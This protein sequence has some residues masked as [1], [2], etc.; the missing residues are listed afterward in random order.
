MQGSLITFMRFDVLLMFLLFT[1]GQTSYSY[2][3]YP[4]NLLATLKTC[5]SVIKFSDLSAFHACLYI[6]LSNFY[7]FSCCYNQG[8][9]STSLGI[10]FPQTDRLITYLYCPQSQPFFKLCYLSFKLI[11]LKNL[12]LRHQCLLSFQTCLFIKSV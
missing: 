1:S 3:N 2:N 6:E 12:L 10:N 11:R 7:K 8:K 9:T 4:I 5:H